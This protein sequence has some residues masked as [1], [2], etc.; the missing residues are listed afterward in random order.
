MG[1]ATGLLVTIAAAVVAIATGQRPAIPVPVVTG[2]PPVG[3]TTALGLRTGVVQVVTVA[4]RMA[5]R[6]L[7]LTA[8]DG[9]L[10]TKTA[11]LPPVPGV[12]RLAGRL[13]PLTKVVAGDARTL[14]RLTRLAVTAGSPRPFL[15]RARPSAIEG[16]TTP[17]LA[18]AA[19]RRAGRA[20]GLGPRVPP[21]LAERA[22][23][24]DAP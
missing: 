1:R 20:Y 14:L 10:P 7:F 8:D 17:R 21:T 18:A 3:D 13:V 9:G 15:G 16:V 19:C 12:G 11:L 5:S 2:T 24:L 4:S 23:A 22:R 6:R